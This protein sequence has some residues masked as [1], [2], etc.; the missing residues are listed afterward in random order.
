MTKEVPVAPWSK[1]YL[2]KSP[3]GGHGDFDLNSYGR[4]GRPGGSGEDADIVSW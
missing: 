3:P 1:P 2:Y 4:D